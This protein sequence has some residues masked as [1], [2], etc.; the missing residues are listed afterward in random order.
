M[1]ERESDTEATE[2]SAEPGHGPRR[3]P[4]CKG[5]APRW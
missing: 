1:A 3:S 5:R 2:R 4:N